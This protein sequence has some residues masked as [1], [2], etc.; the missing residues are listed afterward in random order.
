MSAGGQGAEGGPQGGGAPAVVSFTIPSVLNAGAGEKKVAVQVGEK[1]TLGEA[2]LRLCGMM[3]DDFGRRVLE[4]D[5]ATPR[6]LINM[7]VN[8]KN[9]QFSGGMDLAVSAGD[10]VYVL[11]A[12]AGGSGSGSGGGEE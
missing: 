1:G 4:P 12:V 10:E 9:A 8:G 11:P 2:F 3:G 5:G 7:Y 6:A